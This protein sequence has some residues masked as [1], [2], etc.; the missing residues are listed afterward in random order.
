MLVAERL[1]LLFLFTLLWTTCFRQGTTRYQLQYNCIDISKSPLE[2]VTPGV[3]EVVIPTNS[4]GFDRYKRTTVQQR[5]GSESGSK[6]SKRSEPLHTTS[7]GTT[8]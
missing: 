6:N 4:G 3:C 8:Q 7:T 2:V 1:V 5:I